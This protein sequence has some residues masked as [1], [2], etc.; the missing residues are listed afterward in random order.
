MPPKIDLTGQRYERLAVISQ[1]PARGKD[2]FWLCRCDCGT[3]LEVRTSNLRRGNTGSCGCRQR[4]AV[5]T[6][7]FSNAPEYKPWAAMIERCTNPESPTWPRYGAKG[8]TV[9][10]SLTT[11]EGFIAE[12]GPRPSPEHTCDRINNKGH[13]EPGNIRWA[14][15]VVQCRNRSSNRLID[16]DGRTQCLA[17]WT[18]ETGIKEGTIAARL[19]AGWSVERALSEPVKSSV[20]LDRYAAVAAS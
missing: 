7:G 17:A 3:E 18:E 20:A 1:A 11:I 14:T 2:T 19:R 15:H 6:H 4:D 5:T 16:Y 10:P 9:H 8:I 12:I 13:Y